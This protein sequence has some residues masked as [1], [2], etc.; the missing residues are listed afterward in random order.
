MDCC[1]SAMRSF[2]RFGEGVCPR[3][4]P[5]RNRIFSGDTPQGGRVD[6]EAVVGEAATNIF[7]IVIG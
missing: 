2:P 4:R 6:D 3:F 5:H 1:F 7:D